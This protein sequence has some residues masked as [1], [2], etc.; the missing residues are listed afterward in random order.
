MTTLPQ[1]TSRYPRPQRGLATT[2]GHPAAG[3]PAPAATGGGGG[4]GLTGADVYRVL[5]QNVWLILASVV[6]SLVVGY[7]VFLYLNKYHQRYTATGYLA[8]E[9]NQMRDPV[10]NAPI[11]G[12]DDRKLEV[13][14]QSQADALKRPALINAIF[15]NRNSATRRTQ[16]FQSFDDNVDEA[17][18]DFYDNLSVGPIRNTKYVSVRMS[19]PEDD[20]AVR[21]VSELISEHV[22]AQTGDERTQVQEEEQL[23]RARLADITRQMNDLERELRSRLGNAGDQAGTNKLTALEME[24]RT[25]IGER[26]NAAGMLRQAES[27]YDS[28]RQQIMRGGT[29]PAVDQRIIQDPNVQRAKYVV[30]ELELG[31]KINL[32]KFGEGHPNSEQIKLQLDQK[33]KLLENE[34]ATVRA[35]ARDQ[36]E[37]IYASQVGAAQADLDQLDEELEQ[38][39]TQQSEALAEGAEIIRIRDTIDQLRNTQV[40]LEQRADSLRMVQQRSGSSNIKQEGPAVASDSPTFPKL[41]KI[42]AVA[43]ALGLGLSLGIAFLREIMDTS[44][45]SPRDVSRVGQMTLLGMIPH[46]NDD[47]Q[48]SEV[49]PALAVSRAPLSITAEQY[50]QVRNRLTHLAPPQTTRTLL[51]TSPSPGDGKTAV[52]C[53]VAA[54]AA[55]NGRRVLLVDANFR[56]PALHNL[57]DTGNEAG[58]S[59][60]LEDAG[61]FDEV[62]RETPVPKLSV[63][64]AGR[65]GAGAG[66][67]ERVEGPAFAEFVDRALEEFDL[68]IFDG[69]PVMFVSE[70]AAMAPKVDG[71]ISVVRAAANSRGLLQRLRDNLK[72]L[73]AEHVGVVLNAVRSQAG[74]YYNRN[75]KQYY[76]YTSVPATRN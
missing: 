71:V 59:D 42:M 21:I 14:Q 64:P 60:V 50:R 29:P 47:P 52:A 28:F 4:G 11:G 40:R 63:M 35:S 56:R 17:K 24:I 68:V 72:Q 49:D 32:Q 69:G 5:R 20:D 23:V 31:Y 12:G 61:R 73:K 36:F 3:G 25:R 2:N 46:Q 57:F 10:N 22:A 62:V 54:A 51:V 70:A 58:F 33:K 9:L 39:R 27:A 6:L 53:N 65:A 1:T 75:I 18:K 66:A 8:I 30:D 7:G 16:W 37:Q 15:A 76:D 55:L 44:V 48:G 26:N 43:L 34:E 67:G 41:P 74:G 45:R 13:E 19:T 38:L